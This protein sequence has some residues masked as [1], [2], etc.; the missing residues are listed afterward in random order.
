[1]METKCKDIC[2]DHDA[3]L[4]KLFNIND[5]DDKIRPR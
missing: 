2:D 1:M 3:M 5:H 4:L